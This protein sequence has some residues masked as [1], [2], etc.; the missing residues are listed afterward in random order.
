MAFDG[1]GRIVPCF[2]ATLRKWMFVAEFASLSR[3]AQ[4]FE[5]ANHNLRERGYT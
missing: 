3:M 1:D 5:G 4:R 2:T